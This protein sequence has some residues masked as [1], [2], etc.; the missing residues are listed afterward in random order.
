MVFKSPYKQLLKVNLGCGLNAPS[1]WVNIDG[2]FSALLSKRKRLYQ[3]LC[4]IFRIKPVPWPENIKIVDVRKGLP[5]PDGSSEAIFSSHMLEHLDF[6]EGDFVIKEAFRCLRGGGVIRIIVPDLFQTAQ[7]YVDCMINDPQ[8]EHSYNFLRDL[9]MSSKSYEGIWKIIY[10]K[11]G[12]SKH[13]SMYDE[14]S[15]KTLL[16]KHGF[17]K[18]QRMVYGQ[19]H[20]PDIKLVED[21]GRHEMAICLE[22]V[23]EF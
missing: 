18:I 21:K 11:F 7:K 12:P 10:N 4:K 13:L 6:D 23:K 1:E 15:L 16:E 8:K 9:N 2:S 17:T 3:A 14:W 20:I 22:A 5:F 19:S